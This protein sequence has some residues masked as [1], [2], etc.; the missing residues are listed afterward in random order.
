MQ[1][2]DKSGLIISVIICTYNRAQLLSNALQSLCEQTLEMSRYEVILVDNNSRDNTHSV[3]E[4]FC[5]RYPNIRYC[6]EKRQGL[7][8]ARNRGWREARGMYVAY[9]DDDCKVPPVWLMVAK[10]VI[11]QLSPSVFGGPFFPFYNFRKPLWW[12]ESYGAFKY[13]ETA[14][15]LTRNEYLR[16]GNFFI[17]RAV[18]ETIKGFDGRYGMSGQKLAYGEETELQRRIRASLP[19]AL[20]Y[21]DPELYVYHLV[22]S[23]KMTLRWMI[24]SHFIGGRYHHNLNKENCRKAGTLYRFKLLAQASV[25]SFYI[26]ADILTG[27]VYRDRE[28]YPYLKNYIYEHTS[29]YLQTLGGIYQEFFHC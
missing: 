20:I 3:T 11:D 18:F 21:Y 26:S 1:H 23:H 25:T 8:H 16:G 22:R 5:R 10:N 9:I 14:R 19:G 27:A 2:S 12:K 15:P 24:Y 28:V 4:D 13:S 6:V 29:D 17:R 7:S